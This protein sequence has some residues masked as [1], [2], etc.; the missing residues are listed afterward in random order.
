MGNIIWEKIFKS[1]LSKFCGGQPLKIYL[2]D[3]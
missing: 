3:C 1:G 2:V